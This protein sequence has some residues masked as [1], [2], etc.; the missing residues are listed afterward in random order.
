MQED[1][2]DEIVDLYERFFGGVFNY[3]AYRLFTRDLAEDAVSAVFLQLIEKY[4]TIRGREPEKIRNWLYGTASNVVAKYPRDAKRR[5][6][7]HKKVCRE[8]KKLSTHVG[9]NGGVDWLDL[10]EAIG[11]LKL[12]DQDIIA[13]RYFQEL[14]TASVAEAMGMKHI[15]ARVCLSRAIKRLNRELGVS[16]AE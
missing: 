11:R 13:L 16:L 4:P 10:Y 7:I 12:K 3:C 9:E 15:T 6:E 8:R 14:D 1:V 2:C 5:G